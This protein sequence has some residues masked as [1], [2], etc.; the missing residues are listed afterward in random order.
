MTK[1]FVFALACFAMTAFGV[2]AEPGTAPSVI[3]IQH[4]TVIDP[5]GSQVR[6]DVTVII[7]GNRIRAIKTSDRMPA[8][9]G[10]KIIDGHGKFLIPGLWDMHVHIAGISADPAWSQEVLLPLFVA[11]GI[12]GIR[13]MGGDLKSLQAWRKHIEDAGVTGPNIVA[14]GPMLNRG[15]QQPSPEVMA[16]GTPS[17][18]HKAVVDLKSRGA[19]FIKVLSDLSRESYYSV[20]QESKAQH[21]D[22]AGHVPNSISAAEASDAGQKSIEHIY[23][24][25]LAFD[26]S[27]RGDELRQRRLEALEKKNFGVIA[28]LINQANDSYS[29]EKATALARKFRANGTWL[30]PTLVGI[31]P[32]GHIDELSGDTSNFKYLPTKVTKE[33]DAQKLKAKYTAK[34]V[35]FYARQSDIESRIL[36]DFH[37]AGVKILAGSDSLDLLNI[38]GF[39]IHHEL[40]LLVQAGLTPMEALQSATIDPAVFLNKQKE[41]GTI[42]PGKI[43]DLVL[44]DAS[45]LDDI[46]NTTRIRA[47]FVNGKLYSDAD[48]QA[49]LQRAAA[50][51]ASVADG[52]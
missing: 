47:V 44:L 51:A 15:G 42:E 17:E 7:E 25:N 13:D 39:S 20:A 26:C 14:S 5:A 2:A 18:A 11:N 24:S 49:L 37:K 30:V 19:D 29:P 45:P 52:K 33:W 36:R 31:Y 9:G 4:V 8:P 43:A 6:P 46:H 50:S 40:A 35:A 28:D 10:A 3:A 34:Y 22:F 1:A 16:V 12:T 48:I 27:T 38:C 32:M 23:Y 21:L 41:L